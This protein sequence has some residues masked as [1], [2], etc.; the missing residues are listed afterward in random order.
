MYDLVLL[1]FTWV[2]M[3]ISDFY[4]FIGVNI[5]RLPYDFISGDQLYPNFN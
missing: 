2:I 5:L 1:W 4:L 3:T